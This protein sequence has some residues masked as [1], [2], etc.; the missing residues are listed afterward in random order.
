M[1]RRSVPLAFTLLHV[2]VFLVT[3]IVEAAQQTATAAETISAGSAKLHAVEADGPVAANTGAGKCRVAKTSGSIHGIEDGLSWP[4]RHVR[5]HASEDCI[6]AFARLC[7]RFVD[8][9]APCLIDNL[10]EDGH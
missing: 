7:Q 10:L 5:T 9:V 3:G 6:V 8:V 4:N 1:M 2:F